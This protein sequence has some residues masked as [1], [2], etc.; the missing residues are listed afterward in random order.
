MLNTNDAIMK[1]EEK[2]RKSV[3]TEI[4]IS[5]QL[6]KELGYDADLIIDQVDERSL[7]KMP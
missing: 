4:S 6:K 5:E 2:S 3:S 1:N 7:S